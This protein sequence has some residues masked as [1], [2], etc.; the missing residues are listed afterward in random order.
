MLASHFQLFFFF[1]RGKTIVDKKS[2]LCH[3]LLRY[4]IVNANK[5]ILLLGKPIVLFRFYSNARLYNNFNT[6]NN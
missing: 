3:K 5:A 2:C 4:E 1:Y 6:I